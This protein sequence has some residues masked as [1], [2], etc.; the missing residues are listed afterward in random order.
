M[1]DAFQRLFFGTGPI[2]S[3][4]LRMSVAGDFLDHRLLT[5]DDVLYDGD[6]ASQAIDAITVGDDLNKPLARDNTCGASSCGIGVYA[7]VRRQESFYEK[8]TRVLAI[9]LTG[10]ARVPFGATQ[11][12][13]FF[14]A[15]GIGGSTELGPTE[16]FEKRDVLQFGA[17]V[18]MS[19]DRPR[20][21]ARPRAHPVRRARRRV[22]GDARH[23]ARLAPARPPRRRG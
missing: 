22:A 7:A 20:F 18:R 17:A 6:F 12:G 21:G 19:V 5:D 3:A 1:F 4:N 10:H 15:V 16:L 9:D 11:L 8:E 2:T 14:E 23:P 13:W